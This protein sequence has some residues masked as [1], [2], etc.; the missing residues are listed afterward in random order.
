MPTRQGWL[1]LAVVLDLYSR[2]VVGWA[3]VAQQTTALAKTGDA[4]TGAG[5]LNSTVR[6]IGVEPT[7]PIS[8]L[9]LGPIIVVFLKRAILESR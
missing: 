8:T 1:Y 5:T 9:E 6:D 3:M 4:A 7:P 2:R